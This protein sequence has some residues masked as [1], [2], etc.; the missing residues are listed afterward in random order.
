MKSIKELSTN[1]VYRFCD[2][3]QFGFKTTEGLS[4][5]EDFIGQDRAVK[6]I[7]FGLGMDYRGYNL[8]LSGPPGVGKTSAIK[9]ILSKTAKDKPTPPDWCYIYNFQDP[10][11]PQALSFPTGMGKV[12]KKDMEDLVEGLQ[13]NIP[14]AFESKEYEEEKQRIT[15][16]AQKQKG[17][18]FEELQKKAN[19]EGIQMQF[20]PTGIVTIP[21]FR[22]RPVTQEE[23]NVLDEVHK[24][25][26]RKRKE[27]VDEEVGEVFK[28]VKNLEKESM[29]KLR[30]L[31]R[32]V[33][34]FAVRD[35]I[36][37]VKEKYKTFTDVL[38]YLEMVEKN[39][40]E[41]IDNFRP[42]KGME[43]G[44]GFPFKLPQQKPTFTEYQVNVFIDNSN[45]EGAP[46]VFEPHPT[47]T[48][49]FGSMEREARFGVLVTDFT[50]IHAGSLAKANGGYLVVEALDVLR[51]PFVWDSLKKVLENQELRI[52]DVYQQYGLVSTIGLRP[53]PIK[54]NVKI[55]MEG[56]LFIYHLLYSYDEDFMKLFKVKADFDSVVERTDDM[57]FQYACFIKSMCDKEHLKEFDVSG[58]E[59]LIEYSS[60]LSGDQNK[61]SV[62][63]GAISK[64]VG[65]ANYWASMDIDSKYVMRKHVEKAIDERIY[66][67]NMIEE[68][69]QEMI[70]KN[71]IMVDTSGEVVGQING[72]AVYDLGDY[73]FG[74]PSRITC[75][76]FMG[77]EGVVNIER[78]ANLSGNIHNKGVLILSG[79]IG[80]KY[81][82]NKPL[83]LSASLCFEQS[84]D[85]VEGDSASAA[86]LTALISSLSGVPI[87]Q[88]FAITGSVNQ[89]GQIQPIGGVNEKIEGF[90]HVCEA[91]GLTGDQSVIIPHQNVRNLMLKKEIVEAIREGKFHIYPVETVDQA[92]EILTG[93]EAGEREQDG[94]FKKG[95]V[96]Y[97]ADKR[98]REL[99]EEFRKLSKDS[100]R[101]KEKEE[102][103]E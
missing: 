5:C 99:A 77:M 63:F 45:V 23:F 41:N 16:E 81:A 68:K 25:D 44:M 89:K 17:M 92:I 51:Y 55:I 91:K 61:L 98:L 84:Y 39:I 94:K 53:E 29:E 83:S 36:D 8:Y 22:G 58:L 85:M 72:L 13:T 20:T 3:S 90:Y 15:N 64:I 7:Y 21:L 71:M 49:M 67:S 60:R 73:A 59:T 82:Q 54:L 4:G 80:A 69:I 33:G 19:E 18:L 88:N 6:A 78:K 10:N 35:I 50:M 100:R 26:V 93:M 70:A 28:K 102:S 66:R 47:Y 30:E 43:G 27:R 76:T 24:E 34:L 79:Y 37:G 42:D 56:N 48:N 38:E 40:L 74:R 57:L 62:Q 9:A 75:E 101:K 103:E 32:K 96:N 65:E 46:V 52:E 12:F 11:T 86:E 97:L 87:K 95:T 14:K 2:L 31:E 1:E